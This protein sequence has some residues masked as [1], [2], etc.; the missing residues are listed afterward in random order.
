MPHSSPSVHLSPPRSNSSSRW[1]SRLLSICLIQTLFSLFPFCRLLNAPCK[2]YLGFV[3]LQTYQTYRSICNFANLQTYKLTNLSA[4]HT[5]C[6]LTNLPNLPNLSTSHTICKLT[7][8][9]TY[10]HHIIMPHTICKLTNLPMDKW[11]FRN[12]QNDYAFV[13]YACVSVET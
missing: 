6:K 9:Q 7:N 8:L 2:K 11:K 12:L 4:S 1:A 10:Q 13:N 3:N 5:I